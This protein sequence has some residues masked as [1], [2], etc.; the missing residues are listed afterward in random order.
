[1]GLLAAFRDRLTHLDPFDTESLDRCMHQF[2]EDEQIKI[3]QIVHAARVAT[4]GKSVGFGIFDT[5][6]ILGRERALDR[7]DR[8]LQ[9]EE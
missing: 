1:M 8:V 4:T 9:G 5:L 2:V 6:A 7:I 3:G